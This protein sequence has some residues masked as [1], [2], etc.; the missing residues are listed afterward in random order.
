MIQRKTT[1]TKP[2]KAGS[3]ASNPSAV[4]AHKRT[5]AAATRRLVETILTTAAP[6]QE[7]DAARDV[8]EACLARLQAYP[9]VATEWSLPKSPLVDP[10]EAFFD[11]SPVVGRANALAAPVELWI[12]GER[13]RG[14]ARYGTAYQGPPGYL[15][16]GF[17]AA[18]F[19]EALG[20]TQSLAGV[21]GLTGMLTVRYHSPTPLQQELAIE[22]SPRSVHGRKLVARGRISVGDVVTAEAEAVFIAKGRLR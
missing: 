16:G 13:V 15:H 1:T 6:A 19:D 10:D 8:V 7:L 9:K 4:W 5:L 2:R 14:R 11:L 20:L 17:V 22:A 3:A 12:E 21:V 18:T